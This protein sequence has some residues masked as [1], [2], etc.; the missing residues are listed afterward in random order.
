MAIT[1]EEFMRTHAPPAAPGRR[2]AMAPYVDD[3]LKLKAS[4]FA[5]SDMQLFLAKNKVRVSK[6]A[7]SMFLTR[8]AKSEEAQASVPVG[9]KSGPTRRASAAN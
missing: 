7:I 9:R 5:L 6:S 2:S 3:L 4:G 8:H 1:A